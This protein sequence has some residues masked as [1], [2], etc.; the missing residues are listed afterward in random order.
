[1]VDRLSEEASQAVSEAREEAYRLGHGHIGTEHLLYGLLA[2]SGTAASRAL[3]EAGVSLASVQ[4]KVIEAFASRT[5]SGPVRVTR[6]LLF[7]DR[8]TRALDRSGRLSL[9]VGSDQVRCE[10]I[11]ISVLDVEGTAGQVLRGL[12][13]DPDAVRQALAFPPSGRRPADAALAD[14][15][16]VPE[17]TIEPDPVG[18][19][20]GTCGA[21]LEGHISHARVPVGSGSGSGSGPALGQADVFYCSVCG[22][23]IGATSF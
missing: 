1:M 4:E 8:A 2:Q 13:V 22:T 3:R 7:S 14:P 6:D 10:H 17:R 19:R 9:R 20:C 15:A 16:P 18:P 12:G 11:L 23:A 21:T 5:P